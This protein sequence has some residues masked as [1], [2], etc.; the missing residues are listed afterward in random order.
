[1]AVYIQSNQTISLTDAAY[2]VSATDTG[3]IFLL[4]DI[5]ANRAITLPARAAGLHFIFQNLALA[6]NFNWTISDGAAHLGGVLV[7]AGGNPSSA[8]G[9]TLTIHGNGV[10][11]PGDR[12]DI[13]C[14]GVT[15][16]IVATGAA[17]GSITVA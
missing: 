2:T 13:L 5:T 14:D 17:A 6:A 4:P 12:V 11:L 9:T 16:G 8:A 1:M 3:K 10:S 7:V 15:W